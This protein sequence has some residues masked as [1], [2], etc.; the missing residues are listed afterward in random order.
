M[1]GGDLQADLAYA[2]YPQYPQY[3]QYPPYPPCAQYPQYPPVQVDLAQ[4][5]PL[6]E[7]RAHKAAVS[8][9]SLSADGSLLLSGGA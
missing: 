2:Q 1:N 3:A 4:P 8:H 9:L 7:L 5:Y 6:Q